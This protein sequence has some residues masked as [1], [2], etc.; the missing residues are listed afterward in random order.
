MQIKHDDVKA[1]MHKSLLR[2]FVPDRQ[3]QWPAATLDAPLRG[4]CCLAL[5]R[6]D[7]KHLHELRSGPAAPRLPP[8]SPPLSRGRS[9]PT[10]R[11]APFGARVHSRTGVAAERRAGALPPTRYR[12]LGRP[13]SLSVVHAGGSPPA[14]ALRALGGRGW[15]PCPSKLAPV[16][17]LIRWIILRFVL[18]KN[19][20]VF[21][22][23]VIVFIWTVLILRQICQ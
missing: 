23:I 7:T 17:A 4:C 15:T 8:S 5:G 1:K 2:F 3:Q 10:R 18:T 11:Y 21:M 19:C 9:L 20:F 12:P 22:L 13:D 6:A 16:A 14:L